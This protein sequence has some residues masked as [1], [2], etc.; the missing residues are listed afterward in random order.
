MAGEDELDP[1]NADRDRGILTK[2]ERRYLLGE[3]D[4]EP[5][6]QG[7]RAVRQSIRNHLTHAIL[8][9]WLLHSDMESRDLSAVFG[10]KSD[11][12]SKET[13]S[14]PLH[15][16]V[17]RV[18]AL[19]YRQYGSEYQLEKIIEEAIELERKQAVI[20]DVSIEIHENRSAKIGDHLES[21]NYDA[22]E[23]YDLEYLW[24]DGQLSD[25]EYLDISKK[26]AQWWQDEY[27]DRLEDD[28]PRRQIV[29]GAVDVAKHHI[30]FQ[31]ITPQRKNKPPTPEDPDLT[32]ATVE[33][34]WELADRGTIA[35]SELVPV[36]AD[37]QDVSEEDVI[38]A[39]EDA[40]LSGKCYEPEDGVLKPI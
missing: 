30:R 25:E 33:I 13:D 28:E 35:R 40:L 29:E 14:V 32:D 34:M 37:R 26:W 8:D 38:K 19:L 39:I 16:A 20:A 5:K 21:G 7:E 27:G 17:S 22:I 2:R 3:S 12:N 23:P 6:S 9:F 10:D 15:S 36:V 11:P 1:L 24:R 31:Q 18:I 4:I